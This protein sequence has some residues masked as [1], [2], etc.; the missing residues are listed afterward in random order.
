MR[1]VVSKV[2]RKAYVSL[3][4]GWTVAGINTAGVAGKYN[5]GAA[6]SDGRAL[7]VGPKAAFGEGVYTGGGS[8]MP[9]R[10]GFV[11]GA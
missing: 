5:E 10:E 9:R 2:V 4:L 6:N 7:S 11:R 3:L 1:R 8:F